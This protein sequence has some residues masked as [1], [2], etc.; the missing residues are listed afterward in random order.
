MAEQRTRNTQPKDDQPEAPARA[1]LG[2]SSGQAVPDAEGRVDLFSQV[3]LPSEAPDT[4]G[5]HL[6]RFEPNAPMW[7]PKPRLEQTPP[8]RPGYEQRWVRALV[9]GQIDSERLTAALRN[10]DTGGQGWRV[11]SGES[12]PAEYA[13][14]VVHDKTLGDLVVNGDLVLCERPK[15]IGDWFRRGIR[16]AAEQQIAAMN[17]NALRDAGGAQRGARLVRG[18]ARGEA[19]H[20]GSDRSVVVA[21]DD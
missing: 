12:I 3:R 8:A 11:R 18:G 19:V 4:R 17:A 13:A 15:E 5:A 7:E 1:G 10:V 21:D 6:E 2:Q 14:Q 9:R 16:H 20:M